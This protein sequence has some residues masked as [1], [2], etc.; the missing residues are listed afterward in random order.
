MKALV[1]EAPHKAVLVEKEVPQ[2]R[3]NEV[4]VRIAFNSICGSDLSF[5]KGVWHGVTYPVVPGHEW[6]GE[7]VSTGPDVPAEWVGRAVTGD[8]NCACGECAACFRETPQLCENLQ[9]LGF[10][11][12]GAC[13]EYMTIPVSNLYALPKG[14]S[15]K[16][17]CQVEPVAVALHTVAALDVKP[18]EKVAVFGA[19]GI[20][21]LL[22]KAAQHVGAEVVCVAEPVSERRQLAR[23]LGAKSVTELPEQFAEAVEGDES[24]RPDVVLEASGYPSAVQ[25]AMEVVRPG[26]RIGL[27]GYRVEETGAMAPQL[28][29]VKSLTMRGVLGPGG[30]FQEAIELLGS[31]A[32]DVEP[33]LTHEFAIESYGEALDVALKRTDGNVRSILNLRA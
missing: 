20:G 24:L 15:L 2:P 14:L 5:Y 21:L 23:D 19:G 27:V 1:F 22:L 12:D 6:S 9:E 10:S 17:G 30:R 33:L 11:R 13:A 26:G 3:K 25:K 28:A 32:F 8:L 4:L 7:V 16:T 29:T 18:G 31:G